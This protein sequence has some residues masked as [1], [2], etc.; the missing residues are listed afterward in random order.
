[1]AGDAEFTPA[2]ATRPAP[3]PL[4]D[5][6][7]ALAPLVYAGSAIWLAATVAL[8][9]ARYGFDA[10]PPIWLWTTISGVV[11]GAIGVVVMFWQRAASRRGN[12]GAQRGL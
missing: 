5:R 7:I 11:L 12:K 8:L 10:T 1:M 6:L 9:V 2:D 4:P 3:P